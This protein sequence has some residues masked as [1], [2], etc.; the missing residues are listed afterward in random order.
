MD[1][2]SNAE[3]HVVHVRPSSTAVPARTAVESGVRAGFGVAA[4]VTEVLLR[5]LGDASSGP[6][7]C[8]SPGRRGGRRRARRRLGRH[9]RCRPRGPDRSTGDGARRRGPAPSPVGPRRPAPR[10]RARGALA[11]VAR[12]SPAT[13]PRG[14]PG[15]AGRRPRRD[16]WGVPHDRSRPA[17]RHAAGAGRPGP[18]DHHRSRSAGCRPPGRACARRGGRHG[19]RRPPGAPTR[20]RRGGVDGGLRARPPAGDRAG[21]G[22]DRLGGRRRP[23]D[24]RPAGG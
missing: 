4:L 10:D 22:R 7:V 3:I 2:E 11:P 23:G 9:A 20:P 19:V 8:G 21:A 15:R 17:R 5:A 6:Y 18:G 1:P 12:R 24:G 16:R 14:G 13:G